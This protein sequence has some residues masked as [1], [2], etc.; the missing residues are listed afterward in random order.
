MY[1][2]R[3]LKSEYKSSVKIDLC[4]H[5]KAMHKLRCVIP[6]SPIP[7]RRIHL[8]FHVNNLSSSWKKKSRKPD[9][10]ILHVYLWDN[11]HFYPL[12]SNCQKHKKCM[13]VHPSLFSF[14]WL[15]HCSASFHAPPPN[16][17]SPLPPSL[18]T[19]QEGE[20]GDIWAIYLLHLCWCT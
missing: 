17:L 13:P 19:H 2:S 14:A 10:I 3:V 7:P 16:P 12:I 9:V 18:H 15:L 20:R 1:L 5:R 8:R 4:Q 6:F 11:F